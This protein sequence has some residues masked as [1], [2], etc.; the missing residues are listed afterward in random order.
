MRTLAL[1]AVLLALVTAP[2]LGAELI[3][4]TGTPPTGGGFITSDVDDTRSVAMQV[5]PDQDFRV[6]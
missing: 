6:E 1:I 5:V 4:D 3:L 2:L